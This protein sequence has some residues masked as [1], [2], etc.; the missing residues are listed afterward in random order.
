MR[1]NLK[2][3]IWTVKVRNADHNHEATS[4]A[5]AHPIQRR[6][7][8]EIIKQVTD[9]TISGSAPREIVSTIR[10][11]TDHAILAS[12]VYNMRKTIRAKNLA[13]KT[14]IEAL[15]DQL[16]SSNY[17]SDHKTDNI[18]HVT[19]LFFAPPRSIQLFQQFSDIILLDCTYK[20]NRF[21]LPLLVIVGTTCLH[22]TFYVA[23]CFLAKEEERDYV[24]ALEQMKKLYL[25]GTVTGVM[26]MDRELAL[27]NAVKYVYPRTRRFLC[28]W[29]VQQKVKEHAANTFGKDKT[30]D[31][32]AFVEA[33]KSVIQSR[34]QDEY[35]EN[36][37]TLQDS[38]GG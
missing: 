14:P 37:N 23:F 34:T 25:P 1:A 20:T 2:D 10:I 17:I 19:H 7:P 35:Y 3:G 21:K 24:W 26:V 13:G 36:W 8:P 9:L 15:I 31:I 27:L 38:Y 6:A 22:T 18:G 33:W 5:L 32:L 4:T 16:S 12:D 11:S 28:A 30:E 29:H